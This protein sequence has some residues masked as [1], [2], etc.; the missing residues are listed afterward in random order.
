MYR[1][2]VGKAFDVALSDIS[3]P[4][5]L[6]YDSERKRLLIPH[7]TENTVEAFAIE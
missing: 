5:D 3:A 6:G 2:K 4:A 1:G 7:F